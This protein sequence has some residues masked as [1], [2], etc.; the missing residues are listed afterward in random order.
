MLMLHRFTG[1]IRTKSLQGVPIKQNIS[2]KKAID[3]GGSSQYRKV[4]YD[5]KYSKISMHQL[6]S[7][8][9]IL[10]TERCRRFKSKDSKIHYIKQ[11]NILIFSLFVTSKYLKFIWKYC[12]NCVH[13]IGENKGRGSVPLTKNICVS[14]E[15]IINY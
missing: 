11:E 12:Q 10:C 13:N 14:I 4:L 9:I 3:F 5:N 8:D 6:L 7:D 1:D 15:I 2:N